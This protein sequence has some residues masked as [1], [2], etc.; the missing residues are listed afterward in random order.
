[1]VGPW[2]EAA[3]E[4][5]GIDFDEDFILCHHNLEY[6]EQDFAYSDEARSV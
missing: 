6:V 3:V 4:L 5:G 2:S 1:M